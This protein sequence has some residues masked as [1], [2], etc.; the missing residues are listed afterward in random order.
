MPA[1]AAAQI[2]SFGSSVATR[3]GVT[4]AIDLPS[5]AYVGGGVD[6]GL[7]GPPSATGLLAFGASRSSWLGVPLP[8]DLA[9][10]TGG[11]FA[12]IINVAIHVPLPLTFD[13]SG[14]AAFSIPPGPLVPGTFYAQLFSQEP[15]TGALFGASSLGWGIDAQT[16]PVIRS[17]STTTVGTGSPL[18]ANGS[19]FPA[20]ASDICVLLTNGRG[21]A[22]ALVPQRS[23]GTSVVAT[24]G[25]VAQPG[26]QA[27][28]TVATGRGG[29]LDPRLAPSG[30]SFGPNDVHTWVS[31]GT[32][33]V[34]FPAPVSIS[35]RPRPG[36]RRVC[37]EL[38]WTHDGTTGDLEMRIPTGL[39]CPPGT[40][41]F[42][43]FDAATCSG[44]F[45]FDYYH[46]ITADAT[47]SAFQ[48][49]NRICQVVE[50]AFFERN[51]PENVSC[52]ISIDPTTFEPLLLLSP[53]LGE[54]WD[55]AT[56]Y[57]YLALDCP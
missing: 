25:S 36:G 7:S 8:A 20:A 32:P 19:S 13:V 38:Y 46:S 5:A 3:G 4:P 35:S 15:A 28:V 54:M 12:G 34:T 43:Q 50:Q 30:V 2:S 44:S 27:F 10:L 47:L 16:A 45:A 49:A 41:I 56:L 14:S 37:T 29:Y 53:P 18:T 51:P 17:L 42:L 39:V 22:G 33:A 52:N 57:G 23:T 6:F 24:V 40:Q 26:A 11:Q 31:D 1:V 21:V 48:C 55:P 9:A